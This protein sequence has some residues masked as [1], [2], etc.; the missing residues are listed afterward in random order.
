MNAGDAYKWSWG[1][2]IWVVISDPA[3]DPDQVLVVNF[4]ENRRWQDKSCV[5][6]VGDHPAIYKETCVYYAKAQL[7]TNVDL[8]TSLASGQIV[9]DEPTSELLLERIRL[10]AAKS[11]RLAFRFKNLLIAQGLIVP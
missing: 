10:G 3:Q 4:T 5:I 1:G 9:I 6:V 8:D 2:H 7:C 11:D